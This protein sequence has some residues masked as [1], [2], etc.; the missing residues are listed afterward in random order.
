M[1][2]VSHC[3]KEKEKGKMPDG[4]RTHNLLHEKQAL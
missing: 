1:P 2:E 4:D 3:S